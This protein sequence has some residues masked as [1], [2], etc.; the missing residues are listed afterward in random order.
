MGTRRI[1]TLIGLAAVAASAISS[2][3][4]PVSAGDGVAK[5]AAK[6]ELRAATMPVQLQQNGQTITVN[7]TLPF[8]SGGTIQAAQ[9]ALGVGAADQRL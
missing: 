3:A 4:L 6:G 1:V 5:R 8:L 7:K 2:A 9:D